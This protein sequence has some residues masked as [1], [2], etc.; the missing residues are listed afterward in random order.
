MT[1]ALELRGRCHCGGVEI[2]FRPTRPPAEL[3][4]R[5]CSCT[6]CARHRPRYT[7]DPLGSV[8]I[9]ARDA[10]RLG[11]YRFG[12]ALGDF[13][14]CAACGCFV[15]ALDA[16]DA[17]AVINLNCLDESAAFS[18]APTTMDYD[19]EDAASR[20]ARRARTWTPARLVS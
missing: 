2:S 9:R 17:R 4:V 15:A 10:T 18:A 5:L 11:R 6:F 14:F 7:S 16:G 19:G 13:L 8:E 20:A 3:P 12:Q 1:P